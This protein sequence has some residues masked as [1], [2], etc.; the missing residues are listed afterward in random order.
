MK[1]CW[2]NHR[3]RPYILSAILGGTLLCIYWW[4][5]GRILNAFPLGL[6]TIGSNAE[7]PSGT[8]LGGIIWSTRFSELRIFISNPSDEDYHRVDLTIK[9][10][11]P[12]AEI[13]QVTAIQ[14]V[15]ISLATNVTSV[16]QQIGNLTT[17]KLRANPIAV[18]ASTTGY[19]I[20]APNLSRKTRLEIVMA[21]ALPRDVKT[22][23]NSTPEEDLGL[24]RRDYF[25]RVEFKNGTFV[26]FGHGKDAG[27]RIEEVFKPERQ[28]PGTVQIKGSYVAEQLKY[29]IS[30]ILNVADPIGGVLP[31]PKSKGN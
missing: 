21:I 4:Y 2:K 20:Q 27:G 1:L 31:A 17:G 7:Y 8:A 6:S 13:A 16:Q 18:I 28:L 10:D 15:L 12:I 30:H 19:R 14:N 24:F 22:K 5:I 11:L 23:P 3:R 29:T 25:L 9:P 26:W